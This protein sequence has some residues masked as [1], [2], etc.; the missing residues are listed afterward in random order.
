MKNACR[1]GSLLL[2][3]GFAVPAGARAE[4]ALATR[5]LLDGKVEMLVPTSFQP[6]PEAQLK[7]KYPAEQR[8]TFVLSN[9][10]GSVSLALNHTPNAMPPEE[11]DA[12]HAYFD[13]SFRKLYPSAVWF[14]SEVTTLAGRRCILLD[15]RTPALDTDV[16]NVMLGA[17]LEGR[18]LLLSVN[19]TKELEG[20]W[21]ETIHRM[22]QSVVVK[23]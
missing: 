13:G 21:M 17:S 2:V 19:V 16:R 20:E 3:L 10:T 14:R 15:L 1:V 5:S 18:L 4:S 11:L 9:E 23:P 7:L 22:I 12:A 8:P 6:M